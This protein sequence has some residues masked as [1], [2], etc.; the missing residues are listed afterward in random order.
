[1]N[2]IA[3]LSIILPST[4]SAPGQTPVYVCNSTKVFGN[5]ELDAQAYRFGRL[6][7]YSVRFGYAFRAAASGAEES[8][9]KE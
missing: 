5:H 9:H 1:L 7:Q 4:E 3:F 8:N 6:S 2:L